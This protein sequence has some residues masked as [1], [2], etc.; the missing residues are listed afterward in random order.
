M[1]FKLEKNPNPIRIHDGSNVFQLMD[2]VGD[3]R[4]LILAVGVPGSGKSTILNKMKMILEEHFDLDPAVCDLD[5]R[6]SKYWEIPS[7][8][9]YFLPPHIYQYLRTKKIVDPEGSDEAMQS[10]WKW[11]LDQI[12]LDSKDPI[13]VCDAGPNYWMRFQLLSTARMAAYMR[14][15]RLHVHQLYVDCP[16]RLAFKRNLMRERIVHPKPFLNAVRGVKSAFRKVLP[17]CDS[18]GI[19]KNG[20]ESHRKDA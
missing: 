4:L 19:V 7:I 18:W 5:D 12:S 15:E 6:Q 10:T 17:Y 11:I 13:I 14:N 16:N 9:Q 1:P 3:D 8:F 2:V 20:W